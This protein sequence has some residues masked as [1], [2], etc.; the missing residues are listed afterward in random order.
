MTPD[1]VTL[2]KPMGN[3]Y[4]MAGLAAREDLLAALNEQV[5][6]FNTFGGSPV[7]VAAGMAV[8]DVLAEEDLITNARRQGDYL[9]GALAGLATRH[10]ELGAVRGA[11]LFIGLDLCNPHADGAADADRATAVINELRRRGVL[12]GAAGKAGNTLKIRPPL[13]LGQTEADLFLE[14]LELSLRA[15]AGQPAQRG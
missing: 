11:G 14:Q 4:P 1:V 2:G 13:C 10:D 7:A 6:Y 15:T 5:G 8:L 12:I 3:G 9:L